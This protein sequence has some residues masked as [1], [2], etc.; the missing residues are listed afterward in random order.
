MR[1]RLCMSVCLAAQQQRQRPDDKCLS[2]SQKAISETLPR[3]AAIDSRAAAATFRTACGLSANPNA[4]NASLKSLAETL[5]TRRK[6]IGANVRLAYRK[7]LQ[8]VRGL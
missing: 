6:L 4:N 5:A 3:L 2:I 1:L 7:P 8:I